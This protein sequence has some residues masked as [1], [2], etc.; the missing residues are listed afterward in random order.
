LHTLLGLGAA[1]A[2]SGVGCLGAQ[3]LLLGALGH[4]PAPSLLSL[5]DLSLAKGRAP[6][7]WRP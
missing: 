5:A 6:G 1:M 2:P 3:G 4:R 7:E